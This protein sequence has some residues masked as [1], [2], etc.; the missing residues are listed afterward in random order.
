MSALRGKLNNHD[1]NRLDTISNISIKTPPRRIVLSESPTRLQLQCVS[2]GSLRQHSVSLVG[3][4]W[5]EG[6]FIC[7]C[8]TSWTPQLQLT[9]SLALLY[10]QPSPR[11]TQQDME[12]MLEGRNFR[13]VKE[14][15]LPAILDILSEHLPEALKFHQTV[16]TY[17]DDRVWD[18]QFYV[19]KTWPEDPIIIHFPG[20]TKTPNNRINESF[21]VFCPI[22][23]LECLDL[24]QQEDVLIDWRKPIFL[25]FIHKDIMDKLEEFYSSIGTFEKVCGD[26]YVCEEPPNDLKTEDLTCDDAKL[27]QLAVENAALIHDLYPANDMEAMEV[28]EKLIARL[29]AYGVFESGELAAW[30]V[31]SYYGAMFSMQTRPEYRRKGYGIHLA[32]TLTKVVCDRGYIPFVVIRPENDASLSLYAKLGF[33]RRYQTVRAILRPHEAII[34]PDD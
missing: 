1:L 10:I 26:I 6:L 22:D 27:Q 4:G 29:P 8:S 16:K 9:A 32:T 2:G 3:G 7:G 5:L 25:N 24:L 15:E 18:F 19:A 20:M 21:S 12:L 13:L 33:K 30:M 31:Q 23:R 11:C 28:F 34:S 14:D 17:L